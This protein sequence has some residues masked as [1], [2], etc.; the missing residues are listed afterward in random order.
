YDTKLSAEE[1]ATLEKT[2]LEMNKNFPTSKEDEK[3]KDVMWD[4]QHLSADQKK[5]L[6]VYTTELLNDVRKKLGLSQLSVSDQSIKFA[7]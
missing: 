4:I 7:W 2:A 6:S 5:E 1:I 3:N